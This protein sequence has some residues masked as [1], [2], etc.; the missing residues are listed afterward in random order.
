MALH[1]G[2]SNWLSA[3]NASPEW[4]CCGWQWEGKMKPQNAELKGALE[5]SYFSHLLSQWTL[6]EKCRFQSCV[7]NYSEIQSWLIAKDTPEIEEEE[8]AVNKILS[9]TCDTFS[10]FSYT[11]QN[12]VVNSSSAS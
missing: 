6:S 8:E 9:F 5:T 1:I 10:F 4:G 7:H 3:M 12:H 11:D 2:H